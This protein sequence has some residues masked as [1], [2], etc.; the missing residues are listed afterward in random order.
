MFAE[1]F[2]ASEKQCVTIPE[3]M[4]FRVAACAEPLGVTLHAVARA[5]AMLGRKVLVLVT[6]PGRS[7]CWLSLRSGLWEPRRLFQILLEGRPAGH[8]ESAGG[9]TRSADDAPQ[10]PGFGSGDA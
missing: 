1:L 6:G 10:Q 8:L 4:P 2:I 9:E 5:G 3:S 7:E